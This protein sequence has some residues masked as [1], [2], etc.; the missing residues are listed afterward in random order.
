MQEVQFCVLLYGRMCEIKYVRHAD[1]VGPV[2]K[3]NAVTSRESK[4]S[5]V[6]WCLSQ[7]QALGMPHMFVLEARSIIRTASRGVGSDYPDG[8]VRSS[9]SEA[10]GGGLLDPEM[11]V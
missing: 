9:A 4:A 10:S 8:S 6:R 3:A 7:M 2:R 5:A 11:A 1:E